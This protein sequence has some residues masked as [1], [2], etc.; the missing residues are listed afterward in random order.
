M[1]FSSQVNILLDNVF[2]INPSLLSL[3]GISTAVRLFVKGKAYLNRTVVSYP[4]VPLSLI[5]L[6]GKQE[7]R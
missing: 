2:V 4:L 1:R 3:F 6:M 5:Y 7:L